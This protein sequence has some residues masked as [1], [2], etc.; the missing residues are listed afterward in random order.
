MIAIA[1]A[2]AISPKLESLAAWSVARC[3]A[4][5]LGV[6]LVALRSY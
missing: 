3:G 2:V 6:V 4:S 5:K 1:V